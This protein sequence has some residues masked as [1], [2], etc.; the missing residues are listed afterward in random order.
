MSAE[1]FLWLPSNAQNSHSRQ[2]DRRETSQR[3]FH[4][5]HPPHQ[6]YIFWRV[7]KSEAKLR[8]QLGKENWIAKHQISPAAYPTD[9]KDGK[10]GLQMTTV[11]D[12]SSS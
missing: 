5:S 8:I 2:I 4:D 7:K 1:N 11:Q 9:P 3:H 12:A 6:P 10:Y